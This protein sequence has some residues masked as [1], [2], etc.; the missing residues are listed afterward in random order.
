MGYDSFMIFVNTSLEVAIQRN[1]QR[2]RKLPEDLVKQSWDEVQRNIGK[3]QGLFG[4]ANF[5]I[6]DNNRPD[7]DIMAMAQKRVRQLIKKPIQN[8]RAKTWISKELEKRKR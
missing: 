2:A 7:E 5:V 6:V 1:N 4:T 8:T 3:Y